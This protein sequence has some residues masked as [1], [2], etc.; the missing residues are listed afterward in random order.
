MTNT[1][2]AKSVKVRATTRMLSRVA[3]V[4]AIA[5]VGAV[6]VGVGTASAIGVNPL[7]GGVQVGLTSD[8]A[9]F[10]RDSGAFGVADVLRPDARFDGQSFT[11]TLNW[12]A[13]RAVNLGAAGHMYVDWYPATDSIGVGSFGR[14]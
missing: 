14:P 10:L 6:G 7:P 2:K 8:E 9:G 4:G 11:T 12:H 1:N 13:T 5:G 3:A